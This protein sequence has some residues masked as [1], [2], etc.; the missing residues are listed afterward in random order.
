M[1]APSLQLSVEE[2]L[3]YD[4][5][6]NMPTSYPAQGGSDSV[7]GLLVNQQPVTQAPVPV[8]AAGPEQASPTGSNSERK[9][10]GKTA[11]EWA[12]DQAQFTHLPP[13]PE[14]WL[15]VLSR[16]TGKIYYCYPETGETTFQ[17]PTG[18]PASLK[19][20]ENLPPGW[21]QMVSRSTGRTYYWHAGMQKSQFDPPTANDGSGTPAGGGE[22]GLPANWVEMQSRSTGKKY[23]YNKSLN[24]TQWDKPT[25]ASE[26]LAERQRMHIMM[27][28]MNEAYGS[29]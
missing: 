2:Q 9:M 19:V 28:T 17:E 6:K 14:G 22:T 21:T 23:Y 1:Q 3:N 25:A 7:Q 26:A 20:N 12:Q 8:P 16:S 27:Q 24:K 13:L 4:L 29:M 5:Q 18:P 10:L 11:N 15:R